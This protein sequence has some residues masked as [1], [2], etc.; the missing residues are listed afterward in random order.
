MPLPKL[1]YED[2]KA[3]LSI[4]EVLQD[5]GYR[6]NRKDGLRYP[7]YVRVGA[8]GRR[9]GATSSSSPATARAAFSHRNGKTTT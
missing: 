5:A 1:T 2:F 9:V 7:S 4:Q 6:L 8:D 3:R